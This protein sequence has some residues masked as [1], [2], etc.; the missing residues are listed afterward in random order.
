[1]EP[2]SIR[3]ATFGD[4][5][6]LMAIERACFQQNQFSEALYI[7]F[8]LRQEVEV[9]LSTLEDEH[10]GSLVLEFPTGEP[11]CK[12]L[13]VAVSPDRQ[14]LG[15]GTDLMSFAE[16]RAGSMERGRIELEVRKNNLRA[17]QLYRMLQYREIR[18]LRDFYG[19]G[20]DGV[21]CVKKL[22]PSPEQ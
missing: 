21:L 16:E 12:V 2:P 13:S 18:V 4:L 19:D 11:V 17:R 9:Y 15:Y 7:S 3:T 5:P 20:V 14:G 6:S 22:E 1:M 8:L 10:I